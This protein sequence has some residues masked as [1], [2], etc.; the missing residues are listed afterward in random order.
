MMFF[1]NGNQRLLLLLFQLDPWAL[2]SSQQLWRGSVTSST[3]SPLIFPLRAGM[4]S[5]KMTKM[6]TVT[7][8]KVSVWT[9]VKSSYL[10]YIFTD[11]IM[12]FIATGS[13]DLAR[14]IVKC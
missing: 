2:S 10:F 4:N 3:L 13:T 5:E 7:R 9:S 8:L 1:K 12:I 11:K 6:T 14:E